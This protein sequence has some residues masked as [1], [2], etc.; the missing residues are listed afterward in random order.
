MP[1]LEVTGNAIQTVPTQRVFINGQWDPFCNC[2]KVVSTKNGTS[3]SFN[4][5]AMR[6]A[7][8]ETR[9]IT[10]EIVVY[11][12]NEGESDTIP[13]FIG[14][15]DR[16]SK[17]LRDGTY[18]FT[19]ISHYSALRSRSLQ[20]SEALSYQSEDDPLLTF[21]TSAR[22]EFPDYNPYVK[23][24]RSFVSWSPIQLFNYFYQA[25]ETWFKQRIRFEYSPSLT[26]LSPYV[27]QSWRW[28]LVGN[29]PTLVSY[30]Y[31]KSGIGSQV[32]RAI[33]WGQLI[34]YVA[35]LIPGCQ[36]YEVFT[37]AGSTVRLG[38]PFEN[39][40]I[41]GTAGRE[42]FNW[43]DIGANIEEL[44]CETNVGQS[45]NRIICTGA[46]AECTISL[47][48]ETLNDEGDIIGLIPDWNIFN[49]DAL[50]L[51]EDV[52]VQGI[53]PDMTYASTIPQR[54]NEVIVNPE[55]S[56][57]SSALYVPGYER[58]GRCFRFPNWFTFAKIARGA[59]MFTDPSTGHVVDMQ[60][61]INGLVSEGNGKN[62][63]YE[64]MRYEENYKFDPKTHTLELSKVPLVYVLKEDPDDPE[65]MVVD[66]EANPPQQLCKVVVTFTYS[67]DNFTPYADTYMQDGGMINPSRLTA[68]PM[69]QPLVFSREDLGYSQ[70]TNIN[71]PLTMLMKE[72]LL[73]D[74]V[75]I[76][77]A[78]R[79]IVQQPVESPKPVVYD[80]LIMAA[81]LDGKGAV[82]VGGYADPVILKND[83][84]YLHGLVRYLLNWSAKRT[85]SFQVSF[86][87]FSKACKRGYLLGIVN[88]PGYI[89]DMDVIDYVEHDL[90]QSRTIVRTTN[91]FVN[92]VSRH[93]FSVRDQTK[94]PS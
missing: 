49:A 78:G 71:L 20:I 18:S 21:T 15:M 89:N 11:A 94:F 27:I 60:V 29:Q 93:V 73:M 53:S 67:H 51:L 14:V 80:S 43:M 69:G 38:L 58:V 77:D 79:S 87:I 12:W 3:A 88:M 25:M 86:P 68:I 52:R 63:R 54:I 39:G 75:S 31:Y 70:I 83:L 33:T 85:R 44:E 62:Y 26:Q 4:C 7:S 72:T 23:G 17:H 36:V 24:H 28:E 64:W 30:A 10:G 42:N 66:M 84:P 50:G 76:W 47:S 34:D 45:V 74:R 22:A 59:D 37:Q 5:P 92:N 9:Y 57:P 13:L 6:F 40:A 61:F 91:D 82:S 55:M 46:P 56:D 19:A 48:T 16:S 65:K 1:S 90:A 2:V 35:R 81:Y 8:D 32:I 41:I